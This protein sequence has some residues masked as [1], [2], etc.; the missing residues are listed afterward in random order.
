MPN[1]PFLPRILEVQIG[2]CGSQ[3]PGPYFAGDI[4]LDLT[5]NT[6]IIN[7]HSLQESRNL[8]WQPLFC[9]LVYD[10]WCFR[11]SYGVMYI[12]SHVHFYEP[13]SRRA[14]RM[15]KLGHLVSIISTWISAT[16]LLAS[17]FTLLSFWKTKYPW[18]GTMVFYEL[19]QTS[20]IRS[21]STK[22]ATWSIEF[23]VATTLSNIAV[24]A[25]R[26][27]LFIDAEPAVRCKLCW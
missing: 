24:M 15:S 23:V 3:S 18:F 16:Q 6:H 14:P 13:C 8:H 2:K 4:T 12:L 20:R 27:K 19:E 10:D 26:M 1:E 21:G 25:P 5:S 7:H 17:S 11:S 22:T 9:A